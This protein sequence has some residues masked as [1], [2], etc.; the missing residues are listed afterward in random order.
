MPYGTDGDR[1]LCREP[2]AD[3]PA[4]AAPPGPPAAPAD[5]PRLR[6]GSGQPHGATA[7]PEPF[8][9]VGRNGRPHVRREPCPAPA[10]PSA[11]PT[12]PRSR[13]TP[14]KRPAPAVP[15]AP[16]AANS[17][18]GL[19]YSTVRRA[20]PEHRLDQALRARGGAGNIGGRPRIELRGC[21]LLP[22][23]GRRPRDDGGSRPA[24]TRDPASGRADR[25]HPRPRRQPR[26]RPSPG[27]AGHRPRLPPGPPG[28]RVHPEGGAGARRVRPAGVLARTVGV[29]LTGRDRDVTA[30]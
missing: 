24:Y 19:G 22:T 28:Q 17:E 10:A 20:R 13:A 15:T 11:P 9:P 14:G 25:Y 3:T 4:P 29:G 30:A 21:L 23:G 5:G 7:Q 8:R 1:A 27:R 26:L 6:K 16:P 18:P 12:A 2:R